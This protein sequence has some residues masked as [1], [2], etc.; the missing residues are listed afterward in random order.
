M[1]KTNRFGSQKF[2]IIEE[3]RFNRKQNTRE[4]KKVKEDLPKILFSFKDFDVSQIPPGQSYI[5]WQE[6]KI[7]AAMVQKFEY[8]CELNIIE[9]QQQKML[10]IYGE[11]PKKSDFAVP[12][13][14]SPDVNWAV[15]MDIKGQKGRVAG[16]LIG[17]VFYVV[18]LDKDHRFYITEK[19]NT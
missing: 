6:E 8:V 4:E 1:A 13:H 9:A 12:K 7:L 19:K 18:F 14:I 2:A 17:N 3:G 5:E 10:K 15:I 11:F 16:H